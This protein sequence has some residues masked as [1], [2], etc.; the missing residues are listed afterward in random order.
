MGT[1]TYDIFQWSGHGLS[2]SASDTV[3]ARL[4]YTPPPLVPCVD[5]ERCF[6]ILASS[7][8][9]PAG[10]SAGSSFRL[11]F[12]SSTTRDATSSDI[13]DYN[14]H[15]RAAAGRGHSDI[16]PYSLHFT[17]VGSTVDTDAR[18]TTY[19]TYTAAN[20]GLP[21]YWLGGDKVADNYEDFYD[22]TWDDEANPKNES[23]SAQTT[24]D[25]SMES[26]NFHGQ[27]RQRDRFLL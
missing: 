25:S 23:G 14:S 27:R 16:V 19:T 15:V 20:K 1:N 3:A 24:I 18:D 7:E 12:V 26:R 11:L 9:V 6:Q 13:A 22:G 2:W 4:T 8:L 21:I 5:T 17:A 10:I